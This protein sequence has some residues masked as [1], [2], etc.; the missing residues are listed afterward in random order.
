M[1]KIKKS[2][3]CVKMTRDIRDDLYKK[4]GKGKSLKEFG[5]ILSQEARKSPL[6]KGLNIVEKSQ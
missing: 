5:E 2:F 3:D 4:Y 1:N 6:W